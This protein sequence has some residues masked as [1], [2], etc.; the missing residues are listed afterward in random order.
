MPT[1]QRRQNLHTQ[2]ALI[3][4]CPAGDGAGKVEVGNLPYTLQTD[5]GFHQ[6]THSK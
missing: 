3:S 6:S 1:L 4:V 5:P 2:A